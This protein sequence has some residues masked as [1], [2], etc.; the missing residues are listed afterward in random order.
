M[1]DRDFDLSSDGVNPTDYVIIDEACMYNSEAFLQQLKKFKSQVSTLW[2]ALGFVFSNDNFNESDFR[3]GLEDIQFSCPTLKHCLRNGQKIVELAKPKLGA[4]SHF[5]E[6]ITFTK[7]SRHDSVDSGFGDSG[8]TIKSPLIHQNPFNALK[9]SL[10]SQKL[11]K[12]FIYIQGP[13]IFQD[14]DYQNLQKEFP[15]HSF[16][17]FENKEDR[18]RWLAGEIE[19]GHLILQALGYNEFYENIIAGL[20]FQSVIYIYQACTKC[21]KEEMY[22]DVM[23]RAVA[24][25]T[26]ARYMDP[27]CL[28][29]GFVEEDNIEYDT[30]LK[31]IGKSRFCFS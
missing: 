18:A 21:G 23:T 9:E 12:S 31:N 26:L 28:C 29:S 3:K 6:D 24:S 16:F 17:K 14:V 5:K 1:F 13:H 15:D 27:D 4:L 22:S 8:F 19:I 11:S 20:E 30:F 7:R 25:L 10:H 2:V